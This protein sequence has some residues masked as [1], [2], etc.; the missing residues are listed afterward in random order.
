MQLSNITSTHPP[1]TERINILRSMTHGVNFTN[2]QSAFNTVKGKQ[3]SLIPQ[4]GLTDASKMSLRSSDLSATSL[5]TNKQVKRE[6][7]DLM[8]KLNNF[9]FINCTCGI[10]LKVPPDFKDNSISCPK[11]GRIHNISN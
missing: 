5:E 2:Y 3:S 11:C 8:M 4:S 7:G 6:V 10:K 1:I 9:L